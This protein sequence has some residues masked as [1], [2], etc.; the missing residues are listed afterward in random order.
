MRQTVRLVFAQDTFSHKTYSK[1]SMSVL[2]LSSSVFLAFGKVVCFFTLIF[3]LIV[4]KYLTVILRLFHFYWLPN[5]LSGRDL[6]RWISEKS[7]DHY[8]KQSKQQLLI[9]GLCG[10]VTYAKL[11]KRLRWAAGNVHARFSPSTPDLFE[12]SILVTLKK[13]LKKFQINR[14]NTKPH[15]NVHLSAVVHWWVLA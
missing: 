13:W 10:S 5:A 2:V 1:P 4:I 9:W 6:F 11:R 14:I 3:V 15:L 8:Y 12:L 7:E